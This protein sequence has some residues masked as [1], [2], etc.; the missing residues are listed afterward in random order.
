ML[1]QLDERVVPTTLQG[2]PFTVTLIGHAEWSYAG[3]ARPIPFAN[4]VLYETLGSDQKELPPTQTGPNGD[5]KE[6]ITIANSVPF[7]KIYVAIFAQSADA[8]VVPGYGGGGSP[9]GI[10][11]SPTTISPMDGPTQRLPTAIATGD[12]ARGFSAY[13]AIEEAAGYMH[14]LDESLPPVR[15]SVNG[16]ND[17]SFPGPSLIE[18]HTADAF[19]WD[20]V[21]HEYGHYVEYTDKFG[22]S[23]SGLAHNIDGHSPGGVTQAF[24]EGWADFFAVMAQAWGAWLP[25]ALNGGTGRSPFVWPDGTSLR[26]HVAG[27]PGLGQDAERSVAGALYHLSRGD[28]GL[29]VDDKTIFE[30]LKAKSAK[31]IGAAWNAIAAD[32]SDQKKTLLGA[33]LGYEHI[34]PTEHS[35]ADGAKTKPNSVPTFRWNTNGVVLKNGRLYHLDHFQLVFYTSDFSTIVGAIDVPSSVSKPTQKTVTFQPPRVLWYGI[36]NGYSKLEWVVEGK[37]VSG[38]PYTP[39]GTAPLDYYWSGARTIQVAPQEGGGN[40]GTGSG[41]TGKQLVFAR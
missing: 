23:F 14:Y 28:M 30:E 41:G 22:D 5:Y 37:R 10:S 7:P 39:G 13:S 38:D 25:F 16:L 11:V 2:T 24:S 27:K 19:R 4:V 15:V 1:E 31:T 12:D 3:I 17:T 21:E 33:I 20:A 8:T 6:V 36:S 40:G 26:S 18:I 32:L 35:P 9:F 34:A 29:R